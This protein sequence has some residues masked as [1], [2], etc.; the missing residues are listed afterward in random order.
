MS[1]YNIT[2]FR[3]TASLSGIHDLTKAYCSCVHVEIALKKAL[4]KGKWGHDIGGMLERVS[5]HTPILT[6]RL[7][8]LAAQYRNAIKRLWCQSKG[9]DPEVASPNMYPSIRYLRHASDWPSNFST[10]SDLQMLMSTLQMILLFL[11]T[12]T[13]VP[14]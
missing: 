3:A 2:A 4:P 9:G 11:K 12:N 13:S 6:S 10:D 8:S 1:A 14:V 7:P 5:G